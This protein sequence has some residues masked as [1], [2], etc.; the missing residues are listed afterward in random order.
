MIHRVPHFS[1][2]FGDA[3]DN[4]NKATDFKSSDQSLL[5]LEKFEH[6]SSYGLQELA[7]LNQTHSTYGMI[8]EKEIPAFNIEGDFLITNQKNI[9]IG[10]MTGDCL[11]IIFY[12]QKNNVI[13]IAHAGWKGSV[14]GVAQKTI[15]AMH[16]AF[17]TQASDLQI[18]FGPSARECCYEVQED[19]VRNFENDLVRSSRSKPERLSRGKRTFAPLE[20]ALHSLE[21]ILSM[22]KEGEREPHFYSL[23]NVLYKNILIN[24]DQKFYFDLSALNRLQLI[25]V[26]VH[27]AAINSD[28][29]LCTIC[30]HQFCSYR[31]T[32]NDNRQMTIVWLH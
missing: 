29:N 4:I 10:V 2:Y 27:E 19:F 25:D 23:P 32:C 14:A 22:S 11:P 6:L 21:F 5:R 24:R 8:I 9:G 12:D 3:Q 15:A 20:S 31:R 7:F 13:G 18:F 26:G 30:N 1:I 16:D 17:D 28:Y